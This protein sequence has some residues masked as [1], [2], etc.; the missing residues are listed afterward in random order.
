[1]DGMVDFKQ[2]S[3]QLTKENIIMIIIQI[4]L[5]KKYTSISVLTIKVDLNILRNR[6]I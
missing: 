2:A 1:M 6:A 4:N 5:K 3:H